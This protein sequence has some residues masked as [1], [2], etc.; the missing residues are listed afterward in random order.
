[1]RSDQR[2]GDMVLG[3]HR[4][5]RWY[6]DAGIGFAQVAD[7]CPDGGGHH[8]TGAD[9]NADSDRDANDGDHTKATILTTAT[10]TAAILGAAHLLGLVRVLDDVGGVTSA[11]AE[12]GVV[13][14]EIIIVG[15]VIDVTATRAF[16]GKGRAC[17]RR[18]VARRALA[19]SCRVR[20]RVDRSGGGGGF[21][22]HAAAAAAR[23]AVPGCRAADRV[24]RGQG[25]SHPFD[26]AVMLRHHLPFDVL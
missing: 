16:V 15:K 13:V 12:A 21:G 7:P 20:R 23:R 22:G 9:E 8:H 24:G 4:L 17:G 18:G 25:R 14:V 19:F 2:T 3:C 11:G 26:V 10:F 5:D 6:R 1:M